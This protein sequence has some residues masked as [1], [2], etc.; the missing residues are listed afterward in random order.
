MPLIR[1]RRLGDHF[2]SC[3]VFFA[4]PP[5]TR[6]DLCPKLVPGQVMEVPDDHQLLVDEKADALV[7][8]VRRPAK[9]EFL[10]PIVFDTPEAAWM[11]DP[12][13]SGMHADQIREGLALMEA[14]KASAIQSHT[15]RLAARQA[16]MAD[17]EPED[18]PLDDGY[19]PNPSNRLLASDVA[20]A[21]PLPGAR[22]SRRQASE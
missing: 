17:Y 1:I 2:I 7:E 12:S 22:R 13:H 19:V 15:E 14:A 4:P 5:G 21:Q 11:A 10:R 8:V 20:D 6:P 16:I 9:D 3:G 18:A